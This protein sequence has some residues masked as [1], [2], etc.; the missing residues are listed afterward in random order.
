MASFSSSDKPSQEHIPVPNLLAKKV[1]KLSP[2]EAAKFDPVKA[3]EEAIEKLSNKFESWMAAEVERLKDAN[4]A[5]QQADFSEET[6]DALFRYAHD[7]KGQAKTLGFPLIGRVANNLTLLLVAANTEQT[8]PK[9]LISQHVD[10]IN[11]MI[12]E[13]A[14]D[15][16]NQLG[17]AL[18]TRLEEASKPLTD[19]VDS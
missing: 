10:A 8:Y 7:I 18:V 5:A 2:V 17:V 4:L 9:E 1:R 12:F 16:S 6:Y 15:E 11:A 13:D 14:R 19:M 3:A